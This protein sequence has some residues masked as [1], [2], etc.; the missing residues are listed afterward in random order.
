[1]NQL[2]SDAWDEKH[3]LTSLGLK[4]LSYIHNQTQLES[5]VPSNNDFLS[6]L[7]DSSPSAALGGTALC[8]SAG[9]STASFPLIHVLSGPT[10]LCWPQCLSPG[11]FRISHVSSQIAFYPMLVKCFGSYP[12]KLQIFNSYKETFS[13]S[14]FQLASTWAHLEGV[15]LH[16]FFIAE[17]LIIQSNY[18]YT[19]ALS[20]K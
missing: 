9:L 10:D 7:P 14:M 3:Q 20:V 11:I 1:M 12:F 16:C 2:A 6:L 13:P 5:W 8:T 15:L 19:R 4:Y 17:P 18:Q